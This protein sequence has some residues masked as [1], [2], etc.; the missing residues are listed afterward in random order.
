MTKPTIGLALGGG[1]ARGWAHIGVVQ[2]MQRAQIKPDIIA[3]ASIGALVGAAYLTKN[4]DVLEDW[5]RGL[6]RRRLLHYLD[7]TWGGGGFLGGARL[8]KLL[9]KYFG[10]FKIEDLDRK[11][12]AVTAELATAHEIW[13][14]RGE[15]V[16]AIKASYALPGVFSPIK[17][18]GRWLIDGALVNPVPVSVCRAMGARLVIAV[19]LQTDAFGK[20]MLDE[21]S[22]FAE[23]DDDKSEGKTLKTN[24]KHLFMRQ[25]F[26]TGPK[27]PRVG[28]VMLAALNIVMDR[29][30]RSRMAGDPPDVLVAPRVGHISLI[31]FDRAAEA[32]AIGE[33][34]FAEAL[35]R[36]KDAMSILS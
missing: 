3:G 11:F 35:P 30:G 13:V 7:L 8:D 21:E 26:G 27:A 16:E 29:L 25:L 14:Q 4:L 36:I 17:I 5:A 33:E 18:D 9:V 23:S 24:P 12:I 20:S 31:D 2:A 10:Q 19:G 1:V 22:Q 28:T 34:A 6:N 15:L 32:I